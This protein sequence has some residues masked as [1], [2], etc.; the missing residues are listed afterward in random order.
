MKWRVYAA[1]NAAIHH[2]A[3]LHFDQVGNVLISGQ[4]QKFNLYT[5]NKFK[6]HHLKVPGIFQNG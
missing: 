3:D 2:I 4:R 6:I 1:G 5:G